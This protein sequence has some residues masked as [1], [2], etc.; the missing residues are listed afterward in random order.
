MGDKPEHQERGG[1]ISASMFK[2]DKGYTLNFQKSY[3]KDEE[4]VNKNIVLFLSEIPK[5]IRVLELMQVRYQKEI[6]T[7]IDKFEKDAKK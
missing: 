2:D 1:T 3:K 4:W 5:A 7:Q 6:Q